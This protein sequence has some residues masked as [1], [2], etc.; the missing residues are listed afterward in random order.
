MRHWGAGREIQ[1]ILELVVTA[2]Q[3]LKSCIDSLYMGGEN[4]NLVIKS[5]AATG[6]VLFLGG[7][8]T[9][10]NAGWLKGDADAKFKALAEIQPGLGTVMMEYSTRFANVYYAAKAGNWDLAAYELDEA[11]EIQEVGETTRPKRAGALKE[12]ESKYLDPL[13]AAIKAKDA[14]SFDTAFKAAQDGC[15][16]CHKDQGFPFIRYE[17][18]KAASMPLVLAPE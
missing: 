4:M 6:C 17:L 7:A 2:M 3:S 18:P 13:E 12:F 11:K 1:I 15:N 9:A 8:A 10:Q 16:A 14:K 5:L